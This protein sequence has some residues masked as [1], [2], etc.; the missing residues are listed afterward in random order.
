[1]TG[2]DPNIRDIASY[3]FPFFTQ[4]RPANKPNVIM[5]F[6][7]EQRYD[8]IHELGAAHM[9]T[10]TM[11]RLVREGC[12]FTNAC[13]PNPVCVAARYNLLTGLYARH[14]G[15]TGNNFATLPSPMPRLPQLLADSGYHCEVVGKMHF[16]PARTH[17][18][19]HR[20]QLQEELP[21]AL[22][23]DEYLQYL[24]TVGYGQI[25]NPHGIRD[26]LYHHPQRSPLPE[27]HHP[28]TWVGDRAAD[29]VRRNANRPFF[30]WASWIHPHPPVAIPENW[31][32]LYKGI[33]QPAPTPRDPNASPALCASR[34][35]NDLWSEADLLRFRELYYTCITL[36]DKNMAKVV[37]ALEET[38]QLDNTLIIL[39][40]DHGDMLGDNGAFDKALPHEASRRVPLVLRYPKH[41]QPGMRRTDHAD[42]MDVMPTI[43]D[44]C[45]IPMPTGWDYAGESLVLPP[46]ASTR[47]RSVHYMEH[48]HGWE[49]RISLRGLH[50]KYNFYYAGGIEE[51]FDLHADPAEVNNLLHRT[52]T[53]ETMRAYEQLK[54][55]LL[56]QEARYG[57]PGCVADG[58]FVIPE[59]PK[60]DIWPPSRAGLDWQLAMHP[61]N[62]PAAEAAK[63]NSHG[64]EFLA[65]V[66]NEPTADLK[67]LDWD[68]YES[69]TRDNE[70]RH[71]IKRHTE[72]EPL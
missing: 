20:M 18:G 5:L 4:T 12:A 63:L 23:D 42:L 11:D 32:D 24:K 62:M 48:L 13:T 29:A 9:I 52:L 8:T 45:G 59:K 60:G 39:T 26:P 51:L 16:Q 31:A 10:P 54:A 33:K 17:H 50:Y 68:F 44:V 1:M 6:T 43:L 3:T 7:D 61:F 41:F 2:Q 70:T 53:T 65:A 57:L 72:L 37:A 15:I 55:G 38:G 21:R 27:E 22:G 25:R 14:T 66:K 46:D 34:H 69:S 30:L 47:D 40:S 71:T 49:R 67:K 56:A 35:D 19:F 36:V 64:Q 28:S 58:K